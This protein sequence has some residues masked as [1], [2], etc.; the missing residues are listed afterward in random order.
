[1]PD[2]C[3]GMVHVFEKGIPRQIPPR[4]P[5]AD[6]RSPDER[7]LH[8]SERKLGRHPPAVHNH[9]T[10]NVLFHDGAQILA[11]TAAGGISQCQPRQEPPRKAPGGLF[12]ELKPVRGGA[13]KSKRANESAGVPSCALEPRPPQG[14]T[15][16]PYR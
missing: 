3:R 5:A 8:G 16:N 11:S 12:F 13:G 9:S 7:R 6:R 4:I 14:L 1:M 2:E 15:V 10:S